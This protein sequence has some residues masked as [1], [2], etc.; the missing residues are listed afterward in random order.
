MADFEKVYKIRFDTTGAVGDLRRM[1]AYVKKVEQSVKRLSKSFEKYVGRNA[2][3]AVDRLHHLTEKLEKSVAQVSKNLRQVGTEAKRTGKDVQ[4]GIG[5]NAV[6][7]MQRLN[8]VTKKTGF[9]LQKARS[10]ID[11]I[12]RKLSIAAAGMAAFGGVSI[13]SALDLNKSMANV[14]TLLSTG[15]NDVHKLKTTVQDMSVETGKSTEDLA[16][17][18]YEVISAFGD[19]AAASGQLKI[20][21]RAGVAGRASTLESIKMLSAVTKGYGDTSEEALQKVS[22]LA[23]KTV[24]L[25]QTTFPELAASMGRVVPLASSMNTSQNE[26][27]A[28][29]ATLTG[30]TGSASEV[31]TQLASVYASFLKPSENMTKLAKKQGF[32]SAATMMKSLGLAKTMEVLKDAT[33]GEADEVAKFIKRKEGQIA[34]LALTGGQYDTYSDKLEKMEVVTNATDAAYRKQT[35]GINAQGHSWDKTRRRMDRFMQRLGD[36]LLPVLSKLLDKLEPL[37]EYLENMSDETI[38]SW[39]ALGKWVG[40]LALA[41][42]AL[43]GLLSVVETFGTLKNLTT[44]IGNVSS[45]MNGLP[46]KIG[47]TT[48]ALMKFNAAAAAFAGG[49]AIGTAVKE[50]PL[51]PHQKKLLKRRES[52]QEQNVQAGGALKYGTVEEKEAQ[53]DK[54]QKA[55]KADKWELGYEDIAGSAMS[56]FS[57]GAIKGPNDLRRERHA[58]AQKKIRQLRGSIYNEQAPGIEQEYGIAPSQSGGGMVAGGTTSVNINVNSASDNPRAVAR[59][60]KAEFDKETKKLDAGSRSI[61]A[62]EQ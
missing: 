45:S 13:K 16:E 40:I 49:Y 2:G 29:M 26:L 43:G 21:T 5:G 30:V 28:T 56:A 37:I 4:R 19:T 3:H 32:E 42:K 27:F 62:G 53:I 7:S 8:K 52:L 25:G 34:V 58:E 15:A 44:G 23:F 24:E 47:A 59:A 14:S 41:T 17:G 60:V 11:G 57:F 12:G 48:S 36:K 51:D 22:D 35:Q 54:L 50:I 31:T 1:D 39:I 18:L 9:S 46:G 20:A 61:T 33:K 10:A 55:M 6:K 38:E